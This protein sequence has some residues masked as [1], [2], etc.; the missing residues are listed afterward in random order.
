M[1]IHSTSVK[2]ESYYFSVDAKYLFALLMPALALISVSLHGA[3]TFTAFLFTFGIVPF[4]EM[5]YNGTSENLSTEEE[6]S[7]LKNFYFDMLVYLNIPLQFLLLVLFFNRLSNPETTTLEM[8]GM[9]LS[10]GIMCA[11]I[12]TNVGHELA[13][14]P[15]KFEIILGKMLFATTLNMHFAVYHNKWHHRY[16]ATPLDPATAKKGESLYAFFTRSIPGTYILSWKMEYKRLK[17]AGEGW[18]SMHNLMLRGQLIQLMMLLLIYL[19]WGKFALLGF[20]G[21]SFLGILIYEAGN[22]IEHYGMERKEV[23]DGVYERCMPCHSWNSNHVLGRIMLYELSRHS[24]HHYL[25]SRKFQI[26]RHFEES[27]QLPAGYP[28][29]ILM[30]AIPSLWYKKIHPLLELNKR[31]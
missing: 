15:K 19:I 3:W 21:S 18:F 11:I 28:G 25:A 24:D 14:R 17:K 2:K 9:T 30:A 20:L 31:N 7:A 4:V 13:H 12:G 1:A 6:Q 5:L 23:K 16:V 29:A 10:V 8:I 26:L 22:Y 27:P